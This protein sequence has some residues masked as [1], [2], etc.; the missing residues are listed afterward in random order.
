MCFLAN[1]WPNLFFVYFVLAIWHDFLVDLVSNAG[2]F[3]F[4]WPIHTTY[5]SCPFWFV[6]SSALLALVDFLTY[7][8]QEVM[9]LA[10]GVVFLRLGIVALRNLTLGDRSTKSRIVYS[11]KYSHIVCALYCF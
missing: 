2:S 4:F 5:R 3:F 1:L 11:F 10:F 7:A 6:N 9:S 8:D